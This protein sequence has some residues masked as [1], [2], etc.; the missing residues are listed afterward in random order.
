MGFVDYGRRFPRARHACCFTGDL[1][2]TMERRAIMRGKNMAVTV[3][4]PI[5]IFLPSQRTIVFGRD[6]LKVPLVS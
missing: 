5:G 6:N 3:S 4:Y 1:E 2:K